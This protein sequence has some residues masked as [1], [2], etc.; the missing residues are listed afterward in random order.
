MNKAQAVEK[1]EAV[2]VCEKCG[3]NVAVNLRNVLR[4]RSSKDGVDGLELVPAK[5]VIAMRKVWM[6][7]SVD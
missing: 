2:Y 3:V 4:K 1:L 5:L 7:P 6:R